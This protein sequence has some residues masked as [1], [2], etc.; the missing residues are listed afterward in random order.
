MI[1]SATTTQVSITA[2]SFEAYESKH[3]TIFNGNVIITKKS[4]TIKSQ[5]AIVKF[6]T[7]NKP[8]EYIVLNNITFKISLKDSTL[9]G[10]C[11]KL[12]FVPKSKIYTLEGSVNI[13]QSPSNRKIQASK[14][15]IDTKINKINILGEDKKP[16]KFIFEVE[17]K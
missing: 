4:D 11:K 8:K 9:N 17:E 7:N 10:S 12:I 5:K 3:E 16:V 15:I 6:D 14:V 13:T 2:N 1:A